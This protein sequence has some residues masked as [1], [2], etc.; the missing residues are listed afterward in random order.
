MRKSKLIIAIGMCVILLI[1]I[2]TAVMGYNALEN[3][4]VEVIFK[5]DSVFS[6]EEKQLIV[7]SFSNDTP[8][9]QPY[10]L[11]CTLFG[12]D[13]KTEFVEAVRHKVRPVKPR[14]IK[15]VY[16]TKVCSVCSDVVSTLISSKGIDCCD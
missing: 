15:E 4:S 10:G 2:T 8:K 3:D 7:E 13:Y 14:C 1:S 6:D 11:K 12:H 16:E 5:P 9:A